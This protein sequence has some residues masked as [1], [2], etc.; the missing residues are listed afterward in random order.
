MNDSKLVHEPV[1]V[2]E[3]LNALHIKSQARYIDATLGAGGHSLEILKQGGIV[4]GID[5][6]PSMLSF[7]NSRIEKACLVPK[8]NFRNSFF[9]VNGN[10]N[11]IDKIASEK[12]FLNVNGVLMDL[13]ISNIHLMNETRGFSFKQEEA[14]LD[15]R[16]NP[17]TQAINAAD[18]LNTLRQE[19]LMEMLNEVLSFTESRSITQEVMKYRQI[20]PIATVSDVLKIVSKTRISDKQHPA[21]KLFL[22][23]RIAVNSELDILRSA[24]PKALSV[25][26]EG[27]RLVVI[28]FHSGEDRIVKDTF[29][30]W[31]GKLGN[32]ITKEPIL[33]D[34]EEIEKNPKAKSAKLRV[35]EKK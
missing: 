12:D 3:V 21:T 20:K 6:D 5:A 28:S 14:L 1:M 22:A 34:F 10:F 24:L 16:L 33:P 17:E 32:V 26:G 18:L 19:Q 13:G 4:L 31:D 15:M 9:P 2:N 11:L 23:L 27:G 30:E 25:M 8:E 7:A 35:F 29:R